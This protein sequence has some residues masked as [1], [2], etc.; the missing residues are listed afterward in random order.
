MPRLNYLKDPDA[1]LRVLIFGDEIRQTSVYGL[2]KVMKVAPKT[3]YN[4]KER[5]T[6]IRIGLLCRIGKYLRWTEEDWEQAMN[7]IR[8]KS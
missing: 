5:P 2:A 7:I 8:G 4:W 1:E 6:Q 3:V